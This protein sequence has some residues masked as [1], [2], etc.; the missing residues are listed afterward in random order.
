[1]N[2]IREQYT[3]LKT[4]PDDALPAW[5]QNRG[6]QFE[7]ILHGLF[8]HE[9]L[10][11]R[12]GYKNSGEQIDGSFVFNGRFFLLEAKWHKDPIPA[13]SIYA[14]KGKIDGKLAG[15]IGVFISISG[16]SE[17]AVNALGLG[18]TLNVILL[19]EAD[20]DAAMNPGVGIRQ[21]L[22]FK[23]RAAA[24]QGTVFAPYQI[25]TTEFSP[26]SV[27]IVCEG[28]I[29]GEILRYLVNKI[30][31][32]YDLQLQVNIFPAGGAYNIPSI[33][34]SIIAFAQDISTTILVMDADVGEERVRKLLAEK[35]NFSNW[36]LI[37][38]SPYLESWLFDDL[39]EF[40]NVRGSRGLSGPLVAL[41][42][43]R[44]DEL[45]IARLIEEKESFREFLDT[46]V[47]A[48]PA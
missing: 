5:Y 21:V 47:A 26:T 17:D 29:D 31:T 40:H 33:A 12:T 13:S 18:K 7:R 24:E 45:D 15:T 37:L 1:M 44:I 16:Y 25:S 2:E 32:E 23:L 6:H 27:V 22:E 39:E 41:L 11:P 35:L 20:V 46:L 19:D 4:P 42:H 48:N 8:D 3:S 34:N 38:P 36:R 9:G 30:S 10:V 14:F 28:V 43:R